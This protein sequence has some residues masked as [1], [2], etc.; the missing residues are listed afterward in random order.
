MK[1]PKWL[2][3]ENLYSIYLAEYHH[4]VYR[5]DTLVSTYL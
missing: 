5:D 4:L 2:E 1:K 3:K